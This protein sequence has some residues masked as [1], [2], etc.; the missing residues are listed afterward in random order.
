MS[1]IQTAYTSPQEFA[2][3]RWHSVKHIDLITGISQL[4][5]GHQTGWPDADDHG[6]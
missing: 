6:F 1:K 4:L 5:S 3:H 2:P